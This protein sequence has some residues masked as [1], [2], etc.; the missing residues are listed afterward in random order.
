MKRLLELTLLAGLLL[1]LSAC[2]LFSGEEQF[3]LVANDEIVPFVFYEIDEATREYLETVRAQ[4]SYD[5]ATDELSG[6]FWRFD[7]SNLSRGDI[8]VSL[9]RGSPDEILLQFG[10]NALWDADEH[11]FYFTAATDWQVR[12]ERGKKVISVRLQPV[13]HQPMDEARERNFIIYYGYRLVQDAASLVEARRLGEGEVF[14]PLWMVRNP[15]NKRCHL[16]LI[17]D[18]KCVDDFLVAVGAKEEER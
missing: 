11:G 2:S 14:S 7:M 13:V 6:P 1:P 17:D 16:I 4:L 18:G 3:K 8:V 15:S 10:T 9:E 12:E 5:P